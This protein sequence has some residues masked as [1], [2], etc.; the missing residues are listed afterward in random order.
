MEERR[1]TGEG[2]LS[3]LVVVA[4]PVDLEWPRRLAASRVMVEEA[5]SGVE[6]GQRPLV[7][8]SSSPC[9]DSCSSCSL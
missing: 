4:A 3:L 7:S 9:S 1:R 6:P 5:C 2:P 8:H